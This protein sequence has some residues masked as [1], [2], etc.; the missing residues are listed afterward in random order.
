MK[1]I[2]VCFLVATGCSTPPAEVIGLPARALESPVIRPES[3]TQERLTDLALED[4]WARAERLHPELAAARA[5][6]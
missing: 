4:A 3:G 5:R 1:R 2:A 6:G